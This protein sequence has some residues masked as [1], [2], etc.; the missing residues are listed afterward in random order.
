[1]IR[2]R[3]LTL[4]SVLRSD[5]FLCCQIDDSQSHYF[6]VLLDEIF[7]RQNYLT[8]FYFQVRYGG[9]TLSEDNDYQKVVEQCLIYAK[10]STIAIANKDSEP[11]K[12]EKFKWEI[13]EL[14]EGETFEVRGRKVKVFKQGQYQIKEIEP[15]LKGLKE[16]WATG[17]LVRQS[18]SSGEFLDTY[19]IPRKDID[20]LSCLYKVYGIGEDG[21]GYR[22]MTG[23]KKATAKKG[24]FYSGIP[25]QTLDAINSGN[26][27]KP[28]PIQN[29]YAFAGNFG[30][31][32][33][34]GGVDI[35]NTLNHRGDPNTGIKSTTSCVSSRIR[36][37][38]TICQ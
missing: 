6:K 36:R 4:H 12:V 7:G 20:G 32:R 34:E 33:H 23:P 8:S 21:L 5:G 29:F 1:M 10:N 38:L 30:N 15:S 18:G 16:T 22:Y 17:S 26:A 24:I 35:G 11:Y 19:L 13:T 25:L 27:D 14:E 9:K 3:L 2:D 31:C 37:F 28:K